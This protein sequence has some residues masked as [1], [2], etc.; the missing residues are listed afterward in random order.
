MSRPV[1]RDWWGW[2]WTLTELVPE[3]TAAADGTPLVIVWHFQRAA[4]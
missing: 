1:A 4:S 3:A 2:L